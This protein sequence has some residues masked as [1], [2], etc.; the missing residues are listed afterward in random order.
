MTRRNKAK[1]GDETRGDV[2]DR[3]WEYLESDDGGSIVYAYRIDREGR[4]EKPYL[5]RYPA[6]PLVPGLLLDECGGGDFLVLI[7]KGRTMLFRG[8]VSVGTP[9]VVGSGR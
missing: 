6:S 3:L 1:I 2:W 9:I 8:T 7:R 4:P 5:L